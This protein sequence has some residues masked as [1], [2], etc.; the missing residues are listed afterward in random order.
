MSK[1]KTY[2]VQLPIGEQEKIHLSTND[3]LTGYRIRDFKIVISDTSTATY[4]L[5][6][7][8]FLTDQTGKITA[9]IDFSKSDL[10][11]AIFQDSQQSYFNKEVVILDKE[12]FNQDIFIN[13]TDAGG[14]TDPANFY[15]ELEQFSLDI[16]S[17]TYH[18]IK[19]IRSRTEV[20]YS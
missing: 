7:Q 20:E 3:G 8:V 19:N 15:I 2:K 13:I 16:N 4:A 6:A 5:V 18:T 10:I 12:T 11:A 1:I 17:S 9:T 14:A